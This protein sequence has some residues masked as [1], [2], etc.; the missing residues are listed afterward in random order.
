MSKLVLEQVTK[1]FGEFYAAREISFCA[2]EGEFVTLLV[3]TALAVAAMAC[4][5]LVLMLLFHLGMGRQK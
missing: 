5:W 1:T 4:G 2:E 3:P